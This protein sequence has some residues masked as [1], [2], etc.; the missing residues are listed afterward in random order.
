[1][2]EITNHRDPEMYDGDHLYNE[3][4][5][6][7]GIHFDIIKKKYTISNQTSMHEKPVANLKIQ[8]LKKLEGLYDDFQK[9]AGP[10]E[11]LTE[12]L[13]GIKFHNLLQD[14]YS[15]YYKQIEPLIRPTQANDEIYS[16]YINDEDIQKKYKQLMKYNNTVFFTLDPELRKIL[17]QH[18]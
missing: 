18:V 13:K 3:L 15:Y 11:F 17:S 6:K 2:S 14:L 7:I 12:K 8:T 16:E 10:Y 1:M 5:K 9:D 4:K